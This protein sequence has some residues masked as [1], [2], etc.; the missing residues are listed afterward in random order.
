MEFI[1][2]YWWFFIPI[3]IAGI[4]AALQAKAI[5]ALSKDGSESTLPGGSNLDKNVI[6]YQG[7]TGK[8]NEVKAL[9]MWLNSKGENLVVDGD[10]G[11]KTAVSLHNK[12]GVWHIALKDLK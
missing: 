4:Y 8:Q 12:K 10:F 7:I 5:K 1:K 2:K 6:L 9:Q 11:P 3:I